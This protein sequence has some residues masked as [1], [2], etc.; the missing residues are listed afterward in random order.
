MKVLR[1]G[2]R[3]WKGMSATCRHCKAEVEL[4]DTDA[5]VAVIPGE[6]VFTCVDCGLSGILV[7]RKDIKDVVGN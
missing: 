3:W 2:N 1:Y 5:P 7:N 6:A 4:E